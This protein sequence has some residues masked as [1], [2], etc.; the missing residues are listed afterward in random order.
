MTIA[1]QLPA[2]DTVARAD[3]LRRELAVCISDCN[4]AADMGIFDKGVSLIELLEA[5]I[6]LVVQEPV[7]PEEPEA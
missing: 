7:E 2:A 1:A 4:V 3:R 6:L 5:A